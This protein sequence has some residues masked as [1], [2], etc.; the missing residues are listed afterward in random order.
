M[1]Q[2]AMKLRMDIAS[3][4]ASN[5]A[6]IDKQKIIE[7][8]IKEQQLQ[9]RQVSDQLIRKLRE[10][11]ESPNFVSVLSVTC[12]PLSVS[13]VYHCSS[14]RSS[15]V[16]VFSSYIDI[17]VTFF[18]QWRNVIL[19]KFLLNLSYGKFIIRCVCKIN[20]SPAAQNHRSYLNLND[21]ILT[22]SAMVSPK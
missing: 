17:K 12:F 22:A 14:S 1:K 9:L 8:R 20:K 7:Q 3:L 15:E 4:Q 10:E 6:L 16:I 18:L 11:T 5:R 21:A 19:I 13:I 2:D